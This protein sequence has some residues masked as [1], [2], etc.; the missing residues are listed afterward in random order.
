MSRRQRHELE[1]LAQLHAGGDVPRRRVLGMILGAGAGVAAA[2]IAGERALSSGSRPQ[3][4]R[5]RSVRPAAQ[6]SDDACPPPNTRRALDNVDDCPSGRVAKLPP[7][8]PSVN[9]CGPAQGI[10]GPATPDSFFGLVN[11]TPACNT[12][13]QCYGTC[14]SDKS[15]CDHG[16]ENDMRAACTEEFGRF[17]P[18]RYDCYEMAHD[19]YLAVSDKLGGWA[20]IHIGENAYKEGQFEGCD[21]CQPPPSDCVYCNCNGT[22]YTDVQVCLDECQVSLGCFTGICGPADPSFCQ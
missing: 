13:D 20:G 2:G 22:Y 18:L 5:T 3:V 1:H 10:G 15:G 14:N 21:C 11:F 7:Y 12:H 17:N 19:Y 8:T 9:G 4:V 6:T 16:L